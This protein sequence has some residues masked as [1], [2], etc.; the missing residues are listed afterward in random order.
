MKK[1]TLNHVKGYIMNKLFEKGCLGGPGAHHTK[2]TPVRDLR[3]GYDPKHHGLFAEAVTQLRKE[4][5]VLIFPA[6]TGKDSEDHAV[7]NLLRL[8]T[9]R[10]LINAYRRS[11][12][13]RPLAPNLREF[14]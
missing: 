12:G 4:G 14:E 1:G 13:L 9:A 6:R 3:T 5:L 10:A 7:A 2:H 8:K 11:V